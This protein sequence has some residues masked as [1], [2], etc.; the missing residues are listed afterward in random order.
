MP[1]LVTTV[2]DVR[3]SALAAGAP[4]AA[5]RAT[6]VPVAPNPPVGLGFHRSIASGRTVLELQLLGEVQVLRDGKQLD[7]PPSR[8]TR[9]LLAYLVATGRSHRR[10]R[11][12]TM[13]WEIPD[14]PR[15]AL[16]WSLSRLRGLVD[17]PDARRIIADRESVSFKPNRAAVDLVSLREKMANGVIS[18]SIDELKRLV[19]MF[20]GEFLEGI[21]LPDLHDFQAWCL[22]ERE[23]IRRMQALILST[24]IGRL[25]DRPSDALP[26]ARQLVQVDPFNDAARISL[27]QF[28]TA[29]GR[30]D[31][32]E[33][34]F[35]TAIRVFKELGD[36]ADANL[37]K[38]WREL[39]NRTKETP[40]NTP[41]ESAARGQAPAP[42]RSLPD[43]DGGSPVV[44][45]A[46]EREQLLGVLKEASAAPDTRVV[47]L[48]SEPGLGKTCLMEDF[49]AH[50]QKGGA[51]TF[52]GHAYEAERGY[53]YG[54]W[55]EALG[56]LPSVN[57]LA[58]SANDIDTET[59]AAS[60]PHVGR[61]RLFAQ[62]AQA[63]F[64][65][66]DQNQAVVVAFDDIQ[67]CDEASATL[68]HYII[69]AKWQRP[70]VVLL[71]GRDGELADNPAVLAVL[72][73]LRHGRLL[74]EIA[75]APLSPAAIQEILGHVAPRI[76]AERVIAECEGNPLFA[77]ELARNAAGRSDELPRSLKELVRDRI[78]R[79]PEGPA[80]LLRWASVVGPTFSLQ[81]LQPLLPTGLD[82]L[83]DHLQVLERHALL[84]A[85]DSERQAGWYRF[86]HDLI[87]RAIYTGISEPRRRLMHLKIA[88]SLYEAE[89]GDESVAAE[90]AHHAG[91]GGDASLAALACVKAGRRSLRVFANEQ[92]T[93][94]ARR[95]MRYADAL[96]EREQVERVIE[97]I[98]IEFIAQRP[99][100][101][102]EQ[103]ERLETLSNRALDFGSLRHARLGFHLLSL[104]RWEGGEWSNARRDTLRAEFVSRG[105]DERQRTL[106]MAEAARCLAMLERDLGQADALVMEARALG[107]RLGFD[108]NAIF[109]ASGLLRLHA[110]AYEEAAELFTHARAAARR[111]GARGDE[112]LALEHH[113]C[114]EMQRRRFDV[115]ESLC[116]ELV[117][118]AGKLREGSEIP[119]AHSLHY[120]CR[121][122]RGDA[123]ASGDLE[124]CLEALR[125]ADAK[126]RLAF[127]LLA[128]F[129]IDFD[130]QELTQA[131]AR[132]E[133][134]LRM[135]EILDR[136]SEIVLAHVALARVATVNGDETGRK[137]HVAA[138]RQRLSNAV[139]QAARVAAGSL[140]KE[141]LP[142][143]P[144]PAIEG[145]EGFE[146]VS[147]VR[148]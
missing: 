147:A 97:L 142:A 68:L 34:H 25:G 108:A 56:G 3:A 86:G 113:I 55:I 14:D 130:H 35:G 79:L 8:K 48:I 115:A 127:T 54:P 53:A 26:H 61:E 11:L 65:S 106:A 38:S 31:E 92:A 137:R 112:F 46:Q 64:G 111:D 47:L 95:G 98:Q 33:Q 57:A 19:D 7:L 13:F 63:V 24:L 5:L 104:L 140:L 17:E 94:I 18:L 39:R 32:A 135:A 82:E 96:A 87:H 93:A 36:N 22:A 133:E 146:G 71:A 124:K 2:T 49:I 78:E 110:G 42:A 88:R 139:S 141:P 145:R 131:R 107:G 37:I 1:G 103:M 74:Q 85:L 40:V 30:R 100:D 41:R 75:L 77:L 66:P 72:R 21:D 148:H 126:H 20:R 73:S 121:L 67:W 16:R 134:A 15:G 43:A 6:D 70:F 101:P 60:E 62:V 84:R 76:D 116:T 27:L 102:R 132:A 81:R 143:A 129:E 117:D 91:L 89:T 4:A 105:A 144:S 118:L 12:C 29:L 51:G 120:I 10:E 125:V 44:G 83:M 99:D 23:D 58:Q 109:D 114:L 123:Q 59:F 90:I 69:R 50:A 45:R 52:V 119:F 28:L 9:A 122:A 138:L 128:A 80:D 136:P